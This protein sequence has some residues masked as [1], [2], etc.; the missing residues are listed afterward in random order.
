MTLP[1]HLN[2]GRRPENRPLPATPPVLY[3]VFMAA[4]FY[5]RQSF[6]LRGASEDKKTWA[7]CEWQ[8]RILFTGLEVVWQMGLLHTPQCM[9]TY[10]KHRTETQR[11]SDICRAV[12]VCARVCVHH[13]KRHTNRNIKPADRIEWQI[14][15][16][17]V[18]FVA[19]ILRFNW[20]YSQFVCYQKSSFRKP[21]TFIFRCVLWFFIF[22]ATFNS[23]TFSKKETV[24][25][26]CCRVLW[27]SCFG[28]RIFWRNKPLRHRDWRL[29]WV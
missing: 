21:S 18:V 3:F 15:H 2:V 11:S 10:L 9:T 19:Y 16:H 28:S 23:L 24:C 6:L 27:S 7:C 12:T 20:F 1:K 13:F 26:V 25:V 8:L 22:I 5:P 4:V 17:V 14:N 29:D